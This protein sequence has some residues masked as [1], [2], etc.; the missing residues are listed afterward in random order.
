MLPFV[1][2]IYILRTAADNECSMDALTEAQR[3][4]LGKY[5]KG[6]F[7]DPAC[8]SDDL[9]HHCNYM[10]ITQDCRGCYN[11]CTGVVLY[12]EDFAEEY[13]LVVSLARDHMPMRDEKSFSPPL[14]HNKIL[15]VRSLLAVWSYAL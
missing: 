2:D 14:Y 13:A 10:G 15:H 11:T 1:L 6:L 12:V 9:P 5:D 3:K 8:S 4:Q 7:L